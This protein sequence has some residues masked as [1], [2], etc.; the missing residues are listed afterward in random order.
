[1]SS[2]HK[3]LLAQLV[4]LL[5]VLIR[6][7]Y[8]GDNLTSPPGTPVF[9]AGGLAD[10]R[11]GG[12]QPGADFS[13]T[14]VEGQ[15]FDWAIHVKVPARTPNAWDVQILTPVTTV[16][17]R[18]G[19]TI[20]ATLNVRCIAA[21]DNIATFSINIQNSDSPWTGI[22]GTD[23]T[24]GKEWKRVYL[25]GK[26]AQ[27]F[28][29]GKY[30]MSI[31]LG[32]QPQIL[33]LGGITMLDLGPNAD[34]SK[35]PST[36]ITY[37]GEEPDAPWRKAAAE[38]IEKYRKADLSIRVVDKN[39]SPIPNA[40][41]HVQMLRQ[42][43]GFGTFLECEEMTSSGP[44]ADNLRGWTLKLFNRCT[45]PIYW[46]DWG[47]ANPEVRMNYLACARWAA[48]HKLDTRGHCIIY[49]GW[50]FLPAF[51]KALAQNASAL[52]SALLNHIVEVT[53]ATKQFNFDEY[54][55]TN[56]LRYLKDITGILGRDAVVEW[57]KVA[58]E[59]ASPHTRM[60]INENTILTR[61]GMTQSEQ[62]N[63]AGWIQYLIDH[64]QGPDVIGM[65]AHFGDAVTAPDKVLSILDRF[66]KFGKEIQITEFDLPTNDEQGQARYT[67]DFL[68]A[69]FS[70]PATKAF[71]IWGFWEGR[72]WQ[73]P[74]AM[75]RKDWTLK[76]NGQVWMDLVL[77][78]WWTDTH[79]TT[80]PDG[81]SSTR[82]F[83]GDYKITVTAGGREKSTLIKLTQPA[84]ATVLALD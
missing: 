55:V 20:L 39:G 17:L 79:I 13:S 29:P 21:P 72:M 45:T 32:S 38:R 8:A 30:E 44:D 26:A 14:L 73:P 56:E 1:M 68:T 80:G 37:P 63:Y 82:G 57:F 3:P 47:W 77:K 49:P 5:L 42:A 4:G 35:I 40:K 19:D 67:R 51:V 43:Y 52:R 28:D 65:Q 6:P 64:G 81:S 71:T 48:D 70:H 33:E 84:T 16:P 36:P 61:G 12:Q 9:A 53:E 69:V 23:T 24:V 58:R 15:S 75:I 60:A 76:P 18:K 11:L 74:A 22:V 62:D 34:E 27:D 25:H 7:V 59:H 10:F 66:A 31:H 78:E 50:Q 83:L 41:V 46:A 54:D 2:L